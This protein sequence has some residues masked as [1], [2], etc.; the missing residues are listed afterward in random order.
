MDTHDKQRVAATHA[1][2]AYMDATMLQRQYA[3]QVHGSP[4]LDFDEVKAECQRRL[5]EGATTWELLDFL[6]DLL[7]SE[8]PL[9][10]FLAA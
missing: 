8:E 6:R 7:A 3:A 1:T 10:D 2:A 9:E 5:S 4:V